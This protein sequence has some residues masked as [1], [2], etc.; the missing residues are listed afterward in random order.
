MK[1]SIG[2]VAAGLLGISGAAY[3][4]VSST[5]TAVSDYDFRG[6]SL[7]AKDPALQASLD[8]AAESGFYAG[9]WASNIDYG[10]FVD[11]DIELD[12][13]VGKAGEWDG[14]VGWDVGIIWYLY[15]DSSSSPTKAKIAD[16]PEIWGAI[17]YGPVK[18]K[19]WFTND[20][21]GTT[22]D[23]SYSELGATFEL[24]SAFSLSLHGG[25]NYGEAFDGF[26]F[27]DY[28]VAVSRAVGHFTLSLKYTGT[29]LSGAFKI[30]D[31]VFN[32]EG[33]VL[34][35]IATTF[36]WGGE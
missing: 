30:T 31:D 21:A 22:L 25:Y 34:F 27:F 16:Y 4:A 3:A 11:G 9:A 33:R 8:F 18:F 26:E 14:G 23:A 29:D 36:P 24:P 32:N 28:S 19:Q 7:S 6:F 5:V 17:S 12:L 10:P 35:S 2:L 1:Y 20:Y 13:Y 15:P